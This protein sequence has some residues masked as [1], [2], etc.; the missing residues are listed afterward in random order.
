MLVSLDFF[1]TIIDRIVDEIKS[2][3]GEMTSDAAL[4]TLAEMQICD[5]ITD[6]DGAIMIDDSGEIYSL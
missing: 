3:K 5:P 1:R 2:L 4:S 6:V